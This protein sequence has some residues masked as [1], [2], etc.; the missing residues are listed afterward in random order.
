MRIK[1][2]A[3]SVVQLSSD[4]EVVGP[5][6]KPVTI[7]KEGGKAVVKPLTQPKATEK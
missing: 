1:E 6:G 3:D 4:L 2:F 5:D 7:V